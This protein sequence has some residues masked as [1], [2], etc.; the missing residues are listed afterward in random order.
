MLKA[1]QKVRV[2]IKPIK[3]SNWG[4]ERVHRSGRIYSVT[5]RIIV[6]QYSKN[7]KPTYKDSFNA[8]DIIE[9]KVIMNVEIDGEWTR[10][11]KE[12]FKL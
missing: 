1:G 12:Y 3:K 2:D 10:I 7:G 8:A 9:E 11:T 6:I 4:E 5:D